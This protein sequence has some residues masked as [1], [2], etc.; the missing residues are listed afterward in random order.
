MISVSGAFNLLFAPAPQPLGITLPVG[1]QPPIPVAYTRLPAPT[2]AV[3]QLPLPS[4]VGTFVTAL[5]ALGDPVADQAYFRGNLPTDLAINARASAGATPSFGIDSFV[6][7]MVPRRPQDIGSEPFELIVFPMNVDMQLAFAQDR[8][9]NTFAIHQ[10]NHSDV[11][12]NAWFRGLEQFAYARLLHPGGSSTPQPAPRVFDYRTIATN[13][14]IWGWHFSG[15][16]A[17]VE[18]LNITAAGCASLTMQGTGVWHVTPPPSCA[19]H[20]VSVDLGPASATDDPAALGATPIYGRTV[21]V[22]LR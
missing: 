7:D 21:T 16:R 1:V 6:N 12:R 4:Q 15:T 11:Y 18:F 14:S 13:F 2:G 9:P 19:D 8:V 22:R 3:A 5:T 10:G 17:P 20:P